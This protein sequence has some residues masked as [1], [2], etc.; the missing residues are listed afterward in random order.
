MMKIKSLLIAMMAICLT[1]GFTSCKDDKDDPI[2]NNYTVYQKAVTQTVKS[3]KK[4]D[5]VIL[6]VAFG[7]TWEQAYNAFDNTVA[8]YKQAFP[9][10]D[11]FLSFS[12]AIC[13]NRAAA[14]EN[15]APR[16]FYAPPFWLNAF[17]EVKY[18]EIVVQSLQVIPG[19]E[20]TRVINYIKDFANNANGDISDKYLSIVDLKLGVPL[21]QDAETDVNLV[22]TE[23]NKLY[24]DKANEGVVAF[25]GHGNPDS[26]DTYKANVRYTQLEEALQQFNSHY[27]V[28][29]VDMMGNFK[30]NVYARMLAAGITSGKVYCHPLMSI[31]GDHGHNDMAGDDDD[32]WDGTKFTPNEEGEV[33]DTSWKMYFHHLGYECNNST[34]IEKG[35]L[36]LPTIRQVWMNH[37]Q[38]AI[39]GDPLDFYHS[40][41]PE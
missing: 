33:E 41:N 40:K 20:Y 21:L 34:M 22:A 39:D 30:T 7:S 35:L 13:I 9:G 31:D 29:T 1:L 12:S 5:K 25:M 16:N 2:E 26:Y 17:A 32:N 11:V 19:E 4:N 23:L 3:Q 6:L 14:G 24:K 18:M 28:G 37:T 38:D 27:F 15:V 8:A 36:E 10:Y